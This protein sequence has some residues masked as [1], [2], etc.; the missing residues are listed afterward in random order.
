LHYGGPLKPRNLLI[1]RCA[2]YAKNAQSA[3]RRY[4]AGTRNTG[5]R[6]ASSPDYKTPNRPKMVRPNPGFSATKTN[7]E[8]ICRPAGARK[9]E[10][11]SG[12]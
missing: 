8:A 6:N 10:P 11:A 5:L 4:T 12:L 2:Q 3:N 9:M 7:E 1:L